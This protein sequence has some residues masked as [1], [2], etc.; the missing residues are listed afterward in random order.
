MGFSDYLENIVLDCICGKIWYSP[1]ELW[2]GLSRADPLDTGYGLDEP[3]WVE[4]GE[5]GGGWQVYGSGEPS[6]PSN[7][8]YARILVHPTG[9]TASYDGAVANSY[10]FTFSTATKNW[11]TITH[12]AIFDALWMIVHGELSPHVS[13]S[14]GQRPRFNPVQLE[15]FLS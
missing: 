13:V 3:W 14:T 7:S 2:I 9:W 4:P 15:I 11:G 12:F 8:G 1:Q 6:P 10:E 5:P